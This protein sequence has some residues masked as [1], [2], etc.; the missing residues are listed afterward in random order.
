MPSYHELV[1]EEPTYELAES[2]IKAIIRELKDDRDL[3][4]YSR[5]LHDY[6]SAK[7]YTE[8]SLDR[9]GYRYVKNF[10]Q[11]TRSELLSALQLVIKHFPDMLLKSDNSVYVKD[12]T[13]HLL[14]ADDLLVMGFYIHILNEY[15]ERVN[16]YQRYLKK[17]QDRQRNKLLFVLFLPFILFVLMILVGD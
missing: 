11:N 1:G 7:G 6:S 14:N 15:E 4:D 9:L 3:H 8:L 2:T 13:K 16:K 10:T 12:S 17:Q 5:D